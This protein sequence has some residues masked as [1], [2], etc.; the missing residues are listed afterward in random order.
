MLFLSSLRQSLRFSE[1]K[2]FSELSGPNG[3]TDSQRSQR[4][5][6]NRFNG[7]RPN[8]LKGP[9]GP[10]LT[11]P[12]PKDTAHVD[13]AQSM[14]RF[15]CLSARAKVPAK[16]DTDWTLNINKKEATAECYETHNLAFL[17]LVITVTTFYLR[18]SD[19]SFRCYFLDQSL[20]LCAVPRCRTSIA[21]L[22][23]VG[24][25]A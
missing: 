1:L 23:F 15:A 22:N 6:P 5:M 2:N 17:P 14:L 20:E 9:N 21:M 18:E 19:C 16:E 25:G 12:C 24:R 13:V 11:D 8:R 10:C 3:Q 7:Q 4:H